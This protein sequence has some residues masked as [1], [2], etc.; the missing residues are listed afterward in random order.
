MYIKSQA[1]HVELTLPSVNSA[2]IRTHIE[3]LGIVTLPV[4]R[5]G[6]LTAIKFATTT[7]AP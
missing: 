3:V 5:E 4:R 2:A 1:V 6:Q 7:V